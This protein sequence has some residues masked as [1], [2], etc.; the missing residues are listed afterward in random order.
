MA[1]RDPRATGQNA[2]GHAAAFLRRQGYRIV[3]TN[4]RYPVGEIDIVA[5]EAGTLV[6]VEVR[7]RRPS[8]FGT[9]AETIVGQK[10]RRVLRAVEPYLQRQAIDPARPCRID[11]VAIR[12]DAGGRPVATELIKNAFGE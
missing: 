5:D 6:F 10:Q 4:V 3:E 8:Q 12:L 2:E 1:P 9:A 7:A 11:V